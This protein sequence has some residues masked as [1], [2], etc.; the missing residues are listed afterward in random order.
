MSF[1]SYVKRMDEADSWWTRNFGDTGDKKKKLEDDFYKLTLNLAGYLNFPITNDD[2]RNA[3]YNRYQTM[4]PAKQAFMRVA[5]S[6]FSSINGSKSVGVNKGQMEQLLE[7]L[8]PAAQRH[9][10]SE[11]DSVEAL[12][13]FIGQAAQSFGGHVSLEPNFQKEVAAFYKD[14]HHN[15][16]RDRARENKIRRGGLRFLGQQVMKM[17]LEDATIKDL[18]QAVGTVMQNAANRGTP[19]GAY[20]ASQLRQLFDTLVPPP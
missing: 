1:K 20:D 17:G 9:L 14:R 11:G 18:K 3:L 15:K 2:I 7:G 16:I 12:T 19:K 13:L 8:G 10:K 4:T 6:I 5:Q